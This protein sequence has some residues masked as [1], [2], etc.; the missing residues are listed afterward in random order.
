LLALLVPFLCG[1]FPWQ[2]QQIDVN[3]SFSLMQTLSLHLVLMLP[4]TK[5]KARDA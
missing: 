3:F 4:L 5:E 2:R 1:D